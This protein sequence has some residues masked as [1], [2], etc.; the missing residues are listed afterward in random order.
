MDNLHVFAVSAKVATE[1]LYFFGSEH[2]A[3]TYLAVFSV[4]QEQSC[5]KSHVYHWPKT[6]ITLKLFTDF[7]CARDL[8]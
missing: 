1:L 2:S 5:S 3:Q 6:S 8:I 7:V 4:S